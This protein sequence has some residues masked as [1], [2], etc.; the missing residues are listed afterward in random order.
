LASLSAV[1]CA[2][3]DSRLPSPCFVAIQDLPRSAPCVRIFGSVAWYPL[4]LRHE[5]HRHLARQVGGCGVI[6]SRSASTWVTIVITVFA[7]VLSTR[8]VAGHAFKSLMVWRPLEKVTGGRR[9]RLRGLRGARRAPSSRDVAAS[10][11][12]GYWFTLRRDLRS[13]GVPATVRGQHSGG[14]RRWA[15]HGQL[16][17]DGYEGRASPVALQATPKVH[18]VLEGPLQAFPRQIRIP[19]T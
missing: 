8:A 5:I 17:H 7:F 16:V 18:L 13:C 1:C 2:F 12:A 6:S 10:F 14:G 9:P 15:C 11:Q 19:G 3:D 4:F